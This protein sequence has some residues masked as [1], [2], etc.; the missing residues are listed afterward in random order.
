MNSGGDGAGTR[1]FRLDA[2]PHGD[3]ARIPRLGVA[4]HRPVRARSLLVAAVAPG[5]GGG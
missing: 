5:R 4:V 3:P 2:L 1:L